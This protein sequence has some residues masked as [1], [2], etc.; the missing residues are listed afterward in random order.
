MG[1]RFFIASLAFFFGV[2]GIATAGDGHEQHQHHAPEVPM[3]T[4]GKLI[5]EFR[6][7]KTAPVKRGY[8]LNQNGEKVRLE[9]FRGK[10]VLM[11]FIYSSCP[12]GIC[13]Y[14]NSKMQYVA[15]KFA[16]KLGT[17]LQLVSLSFDDMDSPEKLEKFARR[18][19]V[20]DPKKWA[21]LGGASGD[22]METAAEYGISFRWDVKGEAFMH[23]A[24]T[25]LLGRDGKLLRV[26]RGTDYK[27]QQPVDDIQSLFKTGALPPE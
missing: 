9:D 12:H 27:L 3:G 19:D 25:V 17:E 11:D 10:L 20:S 8:F 13:Q 23:T 14:L 4:A 16:A 7:K 24:R 5:Q 18:Y 2:S 21:Y 15:K 6:D 26:Y 22:I 1:K